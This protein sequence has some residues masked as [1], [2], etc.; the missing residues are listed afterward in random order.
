MSG[1]SRGATPGPSG[2]W[3]QPLRRDSGGLVPGVVAARVRG[4][5]GAR[6]LPRPVQ[7][8]ALWPGSPA[9]TAGPADPGAAALGSRVEC[10]LGPHHHR[11][12][13]PCRPVQRPRMAELQGG[14]ARLPQRRVARPGQLYRYERTNPHPPPG[15]LPVP[16][17]RP[18]APPPP[19]CPQFWPLGP[20]IVLGTETP[21]TSDANTTSSHTGGASST[22]TR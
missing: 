1:A 13:G 5:L 21:P 15:P 14:G 8:A 17:P 3:E 4:A 7:V 22:P 19:S 18:S 9:G 16:P 6:C 10:Q 20:S 11:G 2:E 12:P